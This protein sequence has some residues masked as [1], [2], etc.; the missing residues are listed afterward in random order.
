MFSV[1]PLPGQIRRCAAPLG[2]EGG[3]GVEGGRPVGSGGLG[4]G[5][6]EMYTPEN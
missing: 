6:E 5:F 3:D 2:G 4:V 1:S